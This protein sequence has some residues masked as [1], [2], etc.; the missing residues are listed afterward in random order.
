MTK[1]RHIRP[2]FRNAE[3]V[4]NWMIRYNDPEKGKKKLEEAE[5]LCVLNGM[6]PGEFSKIING[7]FKDYTFSQLLEINKI[8]NKK[9]RTK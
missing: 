8:I 5:R 3:I 2:E 1:A 9:K 6:Q 4:A 7:D